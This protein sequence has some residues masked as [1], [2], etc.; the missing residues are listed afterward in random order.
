MK[1]RK[2]LFSEDVACDSKYFKGEELMSL[3]KDLYRRFLRSRWLNPLAPLRIL[4]KI[5]NWEDFVYICRIGFYGLKLV[6][7]LV[8]H[9]KTVNSKVLRV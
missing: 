1:D 3:Q 4:N 7:K 2:M 9:E 8:S 5:R 6:S